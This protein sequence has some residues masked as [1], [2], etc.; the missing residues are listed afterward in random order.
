M[1]RALE[2]G[3]RRL[4]PVSMHNARRYDMKRSTRNDTGLAGL[5]IAVTGGTSGLGLALVREWHRA[6]AQV[7]F[8]ARHAEAVERL[9]AELHGSVG[10]VGD[11]SNKGHIHLIALQ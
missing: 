3:R 2:C 6:G 5:R 1:D 7:A 9:A 4:H 11:V 10:I 8:V